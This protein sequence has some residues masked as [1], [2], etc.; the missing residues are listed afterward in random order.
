MNTKLEKDNHQ[1][2]I[3]IKK[4]VEHLQPNK[5]CVGGLN[6]RCN[7]T[8]ILTA[9]NRRSSLQ[10]EPREHAENLACGRESE[11]PHLER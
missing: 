6:I 7:D 4:Q 3:E 11:L 8:H 2:L 9:V 1:L 5:Q 10:S